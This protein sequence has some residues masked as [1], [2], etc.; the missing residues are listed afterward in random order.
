MSIKKIITGLT[1]SMLLNSGMVWAGPDKTT[2]LLIDTPASLFDLGVL[3]DIK[4]A[5]MWFNIAVYNGF[6]KA[7]ENKVI[8]SEMLS[9]PQLIEAKNMSSRCL[10][11][12]YTDC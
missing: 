12:G 10:A 5:Y 7:S 4:R 1:L 2:S 3:T 9:Y 8:A 6:N 11:S